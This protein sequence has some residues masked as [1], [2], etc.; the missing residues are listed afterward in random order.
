M[1]KDLIIMFLG[2][3][4]IVTQIVSIQLREINHKTSLFIQ[5]FKELKGT[6]ITTQDSAQ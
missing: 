4:S 5:S 6:I 2:K 3:S 1:K